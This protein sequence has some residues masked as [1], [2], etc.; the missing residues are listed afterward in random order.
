VSPFVLQYTERRP[1]DL[2]DP[3]G[4]PIEILRETSKL[5]EKKVKEL[6]LE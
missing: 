2:D 6:I 5:I 3:S 1:G 4:G